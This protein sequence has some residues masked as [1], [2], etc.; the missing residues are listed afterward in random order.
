MSD[1]SYLIRLEAVNVMVRALSSLSYHIMHDG[2]CSVVEQD[3]NS[4]AAH[5]Y[6]RTIEMSFKV[7]DFEMLE[8]YINNR[9]SC[10]N[11]CVCIICLFYCVP[12]LDK[13][14]SV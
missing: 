9:N 13:K 2:E 14:D 3:I 7:V 11:E 6:W 1:N 5:F 10:N 8:N 12:G 4:L